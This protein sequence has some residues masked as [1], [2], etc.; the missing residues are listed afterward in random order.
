MDVFF[1]GSRDAPLYGALYRADPVTRRLGIVVCPSWGVEADCSTGLVHGLALVAARL[2]GAG[3]VFHYPGY[4]DSPG[5]L[6]AATME[7]LA[8]AARGAVAAAASRAPEVDWRLAGF[9]FGASVAALAQPGCAARGLVLLQPALRPGAY[10]RQVARGAGRAALGAS[11]DG[12][13]FGYPVPAAIVERADEAD[14]A[15][16]HALTQS[17]GEG[18]AVRYTTPDE[19]APAPL[20]EVLVPGSWRFAARSQPGLLEAAREWLAARAPAREA[21]TP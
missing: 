4:G 10:L 14:A 20:D 18:V 2:G 13:A 11:A 15:V 19:A 17:E 6:A 3:A 9:G 8:A 12:L 1:F 5:D 21:A 16:A 7:E